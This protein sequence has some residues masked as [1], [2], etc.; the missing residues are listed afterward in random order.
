LP[1][2][3]RVVGT[4]DKFKMISLGDQILVGVSGGPD[5]LALLHILTRL[6]DK[7]GLG[8]YPVHLDHM[9]RGKESQ[10]DALFVANFC[11]ELKL[12]LIQD[13]I[14]VPAYLVENKV[15]SQQGARDVRY[16]F[17]REVAQKVGANK[18]AVGHHAGDQAETVL[19]NLIRG[20]GLKGLKGI[21][22]VRDDI[23]RPLLEISKEDILDYCKDWNLSSRTDS[24]NLK[25]VYFRNK[26][27]LELMPLLQEQYNSGVVDSLIR[28]SEIVR[29]EDEYLE[30]LAEKALKKVIHS[31]GEERIAIGLEEFS[32]LPCAIKRRLL[33]SVWKSLAGENQGLSYKHVESVI[34]AAD[35]G[36]DNC[37]VQMPGGLFAVK[38]YGLLEIIKKDSLPPIG[39][40]QYRLNIP[41]ITSIP[42]INKDIVTEI[43]DRKDCENPKKLSA[44][45]A[46]LDFEKL[47]DPLFVRKRREGDVFLPFGGGTVK[48]KKFLI[49]LKIP[50]E[51]RDSIPIVTTGEN[52]VWLAGLRSAEKWKITDETKSCLKLTLIDI[53]NY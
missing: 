34:E 38:R 18:L 42:E 46:L 3:S 21:P 27:R 20:A 14:D 36:G 53:A 28:L 35:G 12:P 5:S 4:I 16:K 37:R 25:T 8:L 24:S 15:S 40:Y 47:L 41:G 50:R 6:K 23:V 33:V 39:F 44:S 13:R 19:L 52:I 32:G 26:I 51:Q 49:D 11:K 7:M 48:L 45:E 31:R 22:P 43:F 9:F 29:D 30:I 17:Y 2:L 10:E 1:I